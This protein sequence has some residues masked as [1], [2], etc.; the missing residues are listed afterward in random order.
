MAPGGGSVCGELLNANR[1][2][3]ADFGVAIDF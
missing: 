1:E 3:A 2:E